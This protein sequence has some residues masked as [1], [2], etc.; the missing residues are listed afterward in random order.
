[1]GFIISCVGDKGGEADPLE[2]PCDPSLGHTALFPWTEGKRPCPPAE[3]PPVSRASIVLALGLGDVLGLVAL[4]TLPDF[5]LDCLAFRQS[6]VAVHLD[7]RE[8]NEDILAR[9][10]LDEPIPL[11]SV[12]PLHHT[13]F[14]A[15]LLAPVSGMLPFAGCNASR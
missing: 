1:M 6:L 9:L 12:K 2:Q 5:K 11:G 7:G 10:A 3:T 14:S 15:Q 4:G 8:V 13:L